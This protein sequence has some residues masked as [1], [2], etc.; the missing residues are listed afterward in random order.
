MSTVLPEGWS[1]PPPSAA[2]YRPEPSTSVPLL[3]P[4]AVALAVVGAVGG[5]A[6]ARYGGFDLLRFTGF[7]W[8]AGSATALTLLALKAPVRTA[9][10]TL[11]LFLF[12]GVPVVGYAAVKGTAERAV[13]VLTDQ[14]GDFEQ[15]FEAELEEL[16]ELGEGFGTGSGG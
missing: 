8:W 4:V 3:V 9:V 6:V 13:A 7:V 12:V 16:S 10:V 2:P 5:Y 11:F 1:A 14:F 15:E